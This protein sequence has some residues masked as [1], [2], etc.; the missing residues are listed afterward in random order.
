MILSSSEDMEVVGEAADGAEAVAA[1]H[2]H[3]PYVVLMDIRMPGMDGITATSALRRLANPP[4]AHRPRARGRGRGRFRRIQRRDCNIAL[5]ER[6]HREGPRL[7][8]SHQTRRYQ[9]GANRYSR[10]RRTTMT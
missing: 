4:H 10:P 5:H 8:P 7:T 2:T 1:L 9:P 6:G 3:R